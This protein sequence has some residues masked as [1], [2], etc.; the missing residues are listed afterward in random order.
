MDRLS[1]LALCS[2]YPTQRPP[3][4]HDPPAQ[5]LTW[6]N[7]NAAPADVQPLVAAIMR[8]VIEFHGYDRVEVVDEYG[9][10]RAVFVVPP[11]ATPHTCVIHA[12]SKAFAPRRWLFALATAASLLLLL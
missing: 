7:I 12:P 9:K 4:P 3:F 5:E 8:N 11:A 10:K 1:L 6:A 2:Y